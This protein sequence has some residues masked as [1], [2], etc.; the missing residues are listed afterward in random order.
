MI[1]QQA[2]FDCAASR[3]HRLQGGA[4]GRYTRGLPV[5][6]D[7]MDSST[8]A[9][10]ANLLA[11]VKESCQTLSGFSGVA[12]VIEWRYMKCK[13]ITAAGLHILLAA[14]TTAHVLLAP[15]TKVEESFNI[16]AIH[17]L[18]HLGTDIQQYDHLEFSGVVPR[19]FIGEPYLEGTPLLIGE[20]I[21]M[22]LNIL[23]QELSKLQSSFF[24]RNHVQIF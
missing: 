24:C 2:A 19:T 17:D 15:Y 6:V 9:S 10:Q 11:T 20:R 13:Y 7:S 12:F 8:G 4:S 21:C 5:P 14:I 18:C 16:Q 23:K 1:V 3:R 22:Q